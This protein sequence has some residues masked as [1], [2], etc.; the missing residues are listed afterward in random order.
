MTTQPQGGPAGVSPAGPG[1]QED[2][3]VAEARRAANTPGPRFDV[4]LP[5]QTL[6]ELYYDLRRHLIAVLAVH[7][8]HR[9]ALAGALPDAA[10]LEGGSADAEHD[11]LRGLAG[12]VA[13]V[14]GVPLDPRSPHEPD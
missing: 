3:R 6:T 13:G 7:D 10:A 1:P 9:A 14:L 11:Q 2:P 8:E 12:T 5:A 4:V